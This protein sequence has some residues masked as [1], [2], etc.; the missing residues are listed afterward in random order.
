LRWRNYVRFV[1]GPAEFDKSTNYLRPFYGKPSRFGLRL[2]QH[3]RLLGLCSLRYLIASGLSPQKMKA[4]DAHSWRLIPQANL[5]G[6]TS[7]IFENRLALPRTY[8]V[9]SYTITGNEEESLR[10]IGENILELSHSVVLENGTPSFPSASKSMESGSARIAEYGI[11]EVKLHVESQ[12][13]SILVL[14]DSYYPGW[15]A[16][17][18]GEEKPI[19]R[20][21]SLFRAV[22]V[23]AGVQRVVF[24]YRPSS[25]YFGMTVSLVTLLLTVAGLLVEA[26]RSRNRRSIQA[27][28]RSAGAN[29]E[30]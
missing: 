16:L 15:I 28:N 17:V 25:F 22:E 1:V 19:W 20:A 4:I 23:P 11:N 21:N 29:P 10:A 7:Q 13:P 2:L 30:E 5:A 3:R 12:E 24:K 9:N 8:L 27:E 18:D 14:T 6:S 26:H